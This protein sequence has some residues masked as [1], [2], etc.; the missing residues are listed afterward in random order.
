MDLSFVDKPVVSLCLKK[1]SPKNKT[2]PK[3]SIKQDLLLE[4]LKIF[5][6]KKKNMESLLNIVNNNSNI[7]LRIIDWFVT[8]YSK[9]NYINI[10]VNKKIDGVN[11][12]V[13]SKT[14]KKTI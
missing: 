1:K 8:N 10:L 5:Y 11:D 12:C 7:S 3:L 9:K 13:Q 6:D 14:K 4:K 2:Y